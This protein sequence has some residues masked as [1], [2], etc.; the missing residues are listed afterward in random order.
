MGMNYFRV[1]L[2]GTGG[3]GESVVVQMGNHKWMVVDS[4]LDPV[5]K[6]SLPLQYLKSQGVDI[7]SDVKLV[8]CSHWHN[9]HILGMDLLLKEC[10]SASLVLA[11]TSDRKKFLEFIGLD[12]RTDKVLAG[13]SSTN[14]MSNCLK[15]ANEHK[16]PVKIAVQDRL[17]LGMK[18]ADNDVKVYALSPSDAM[19]ADFGTE[20]STLI[21]DYTSKSNQRI[22]VRSPN[23][24]CIVLQVCVNEHTV[25]LGGDLEKSDADNRGWLCILNHCDCVKNAKASLF[26]IPH[27][28]SEN[29]YEDE[30]W[31]KLFNHKV[32]VG[33]LSPFFHG[34]SSLP[35]KEML[36]KFLEMVQHLYITSY[37]KP[38]KP[39]K[40]EKSMEKMIQ[41]SNAT[42]KEIT[43]QKGIIE[44]YINLDEKEGKWETKLYEKAFEINDNF[45]NRL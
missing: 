12:S 43:F 2:I 41:K 29:A 34:R 14:I 22:I 19:I 33:Q 7:A 10:K 9:D 25:I 39:K 38:T 16:I 35:S 5:S 27:H 32:L 8:V 15:I 3:Y 21:K 4:C 18:D 13:T 20:L 26:K 45:V 17:L 24:K 1:S 36:I 44:N 42:L 40:R 37:N 30:V 31:E 28:G 11:I 6:E 23:E